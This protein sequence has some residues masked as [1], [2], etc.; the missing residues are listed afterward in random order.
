MTP[1]LTVLGM[2]FIV[3]AVLWPLAYFGQKYW[4]DLVK[5]EEEKHAQE[6]VKH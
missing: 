6:G 1:I 3:L 5:A 2:A 4:K